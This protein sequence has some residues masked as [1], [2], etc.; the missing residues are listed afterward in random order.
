VAPKANAAFWADKIAQNRARDLRKDRQ[1]QELGWKV[2]HV[3][4]HDDAEAAAER[5]AA[6]RLGGAG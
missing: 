3:W 4:E 6:L 2:I 1:L 5:I